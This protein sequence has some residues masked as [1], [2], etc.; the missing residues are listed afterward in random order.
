MSNLTYT[1]DF[2]IRFANAAKNG[3][4]VCAAIL[5]AIKTPNN[6]RDS[7][8][9]DYLTTKRIRHGANENFIKKSIVVTVCSKD[10][11]NK[12]NPEHGSPV[13]MWRPENRRNISLPDLVDAFKSLDS[14]DFTSDDYQYASSILCADEPIKVAIYSKMQD[15]ERGYLGDNYIEVFSGDGT[16]QNSCMRHEGTARVAGDFYANFAGAK[17]VLATGT[18]T[19]KIYGRAILWPNIEV[20]GV[21]GSFLDRTYYAHDAVMHMIR[22]YAKEHGVRFRKYRNT[23]TDK[24]SFVDMTTGERYDNVIVSVRVPANK[25]HKEGSPYMDTFSYLFYNDGQF[26]L[27]NFCRLN[28]SS[29]HVADL[30]CTGEHANIVRHICPVCGNVH[31]NDYI[32]LSCERTY[33][34]M[35]AV[36]RVWIGKTN[37]NHE[38]VLSKKY[39]KDNERLSRI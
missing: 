39:V 21:S 20:S 6:V 5:K 26:A 31:S 1:E 23:Y 29:N 4:K 28:G 10:F 33:I 35:T 19:G 36:G 2:R 7:V 16:L 3:S 18:V 9:F 32:C 25:W 14:N 27:A 17:I 34:K 11:S 24:N 38:P 8:K 37:K 13:G 22:S 15:I 12:E 30:A